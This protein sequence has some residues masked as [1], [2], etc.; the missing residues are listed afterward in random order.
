MKETGEVIILLYYTENTT[1]KQTL[2]R[3]CRIAH[4]LASSVKELTGTLQ[5]YPFK[6]KGTSGVGADN[7]GYTQLFL[8]CTFLHCMFI[9]PSSPNQNFG[10]LVT[11]AQR[12]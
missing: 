1:L 2:N 11:S 6:R 9:L 8:M 10:V 3:A 12:C 5:S 4:R 7:F